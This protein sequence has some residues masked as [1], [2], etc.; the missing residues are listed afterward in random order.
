V[1]VS[2]LNNL[3]TFRNSHTCL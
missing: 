2:L 1:I 3:F